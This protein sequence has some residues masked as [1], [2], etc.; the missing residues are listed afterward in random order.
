MKVLEQIVAVLAV[1]ALIVVPLL[2][3]LAAA[4]ARWHGREKLGPIEVQGSAFYPACRSRSGL[5]A[6]VAAS[7]S[8]DL[9]LL[10]LVVIRLLGDSSTTALFWLVGVM[11]T[12]VGMVAAIFAKRGVRG[13]AFV[14]SI[15]CLFWCWLVFGLGLVASSSD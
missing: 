12:L 3:P 7:V 11:S 9:L 10:Y 14:S 13:L 4:W 8:L 1:I 5:T 2:V 6:L 15:V